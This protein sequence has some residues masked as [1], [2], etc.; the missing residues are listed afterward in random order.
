MINPQLN[1]T[2]SNFQKI[3]SY[4]PLLLLTTLFLSCNSLK[5]FDREQELN[6]YL[7]KVHYID[8]KHPK[9]V[10]LLQTNFCGACS[11]EVIT[12]IS[13]ELKQSKMQTIIILSK[14]DKKIISEL[15]SL[16]NKEVVILIDREYE[17]EKYG[18][19]FTS[20]LIFL[21]ENSSISFWEFIEEEKF[22]EIK[23]I[24]SQANKKTVSNKPYNGN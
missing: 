17:L 11:Q 2:Y 8:L 7:T 22:S 19:L 23:R 3:K 9:I 20:D 24:F 15:S 14:E 5:K 4:F 13:N 6:S 12:F 10:I 1:L 16:N 18:L 21:F